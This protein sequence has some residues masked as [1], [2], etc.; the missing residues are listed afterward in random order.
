MAIGWLITDVTKKGAGLW[1]EVL[2]GL[3]LAA[4]A[5]MMQRERHTGAI[6]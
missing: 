3:A 5:V 4:G 6:G 1:L 2:G